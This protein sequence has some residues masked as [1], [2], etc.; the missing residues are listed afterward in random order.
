[1]LRTRCRSERLRTGGHQVRR[2]GL[3]L[4]ELRKRDRMTVSGAL[5]VLNS[6]VERPRTPWIETRECVIC[7]AEPKAVRFGC[8][9]STYCRTCLKVR[10]LS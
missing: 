3:Q 4:V 6:L 5:E 2:V 8:G 1:M 7:L 10:A 9:H